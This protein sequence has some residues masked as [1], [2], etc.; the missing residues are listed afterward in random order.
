MRKGCGIAPFALRGRNVCATDPIDIGLIPAAKS[1][2]F[3]AT[4]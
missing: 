2:D 3:L 4:F 1:G